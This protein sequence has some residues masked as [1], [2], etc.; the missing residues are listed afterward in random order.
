MKIVSTQYLAF[1][2]AVH[3]MLSYQIGHVIWKDCSTFQLS[4]KEKS[5]KRDVSRD[6]EK[7]RQNNDQTRIENEYKKL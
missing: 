2:L 4:Q 6:F 1:L 3:G 5:I 7:I